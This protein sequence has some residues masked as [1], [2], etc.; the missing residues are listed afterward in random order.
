MSRSRNPRLIFIYKQME[1][2]RSRFDFHQNILYMYMFCCVCV[3]F[4]IIFLVCVMNESVVALLFKPTVLC[5][6]TSF[7]Y[8][9]SPLL[10]LKHNSRLKNPLPNG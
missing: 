10:L 4:T 6:I 5:D 2:L 8:Q 7:G 1:N 3:L 9:N